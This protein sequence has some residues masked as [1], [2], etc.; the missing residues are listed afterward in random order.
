MDERLPGVGRVGK[1][2]VVTDPLRKRLKA[3][4]LSLL[5]P[6]PL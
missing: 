3:T 5:I 1:A 4:D 2:I 6:S